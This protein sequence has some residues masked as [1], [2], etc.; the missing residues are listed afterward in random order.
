L[1]R[2]RAFE[3]KDVE[4]V[5]GLHRSVFRLKVA[6]PVERYHSYFVEQFLPRDPLASPSLVSES[7]H[8]RITGFLGVAARQFCFGDRRI[9]AALSS[10]F[11]VAPEGRKQLAGIN[12][13]REF[14]NGRQDLSFTDEANDL[15]QKIWVA[16]GGSVSTLQ[17]IHW[18]VPLRPVSLACNRYAPGWM[19][20]LLGVPAS[21]FDR[22]VSWV[23]NGLIRD[24]GP[25]LKNETLS[26]E[27]MI[28]YLNKA[29]RRCQL[30]PHYDQ[31]S[32]ATTI[33]RAA[34]KKGALRKVLLKDKANNVAG[35]YLYHC[36]PGGLA[37]VL[38]IVS[39]ED[40]QI[41]VIAHLSSDAREHGATAAVGRLEPGLAEPLANRFCFFFRRKYAMLV[42][43]RFPEIISAI[44]SGQAFI[45][46][47][48]GEW[49]LRY[50]N[51]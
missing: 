45:S 7:Q 26:T 32:L 41:P 27:G 37:E 9:V 22:L 48:E 49:C 39:Q 24:N 46:R 47:L 15:S 42:H 30:R 13:I 35:W 18:F 1:D 12:L 10:Q 34:Q 8:G 16:L 19:A 28:E 43:S 31:T 36:E 6:P 29:T 51:T 44:H 11:V 17:G 25:V 21:M 23:T 14:L 50:C 40:Y 38:Q 5:S 33:Q 3:R 4:Q 20:P 2:I